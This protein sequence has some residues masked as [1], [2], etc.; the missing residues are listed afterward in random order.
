MNMTKVYGMH[1][2]SVLWNELVKTVFSVMQ[3]QPVNAQL[4]ECC[5]GNS[6][7]WKM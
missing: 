3:V 6:T 5:L 2:F 1:L 7:V 4:W